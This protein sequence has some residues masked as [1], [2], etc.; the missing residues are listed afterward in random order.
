MYLV[1]NG[2]DKFAY[3]LFID[4]LTIFHR[5]ISLSQTFKCQTV[6]QFL[7]DKRVPD[8]WYSNINA[9]SVPNYCI[10]YFTLL[11]SY[12]ANHYHLLLFGYIYMTFSIFFHLAIIIYLIKM[13][14]TSV[15]TEQVRSS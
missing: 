1:C 12:I 2:I 13:G 4:F 9:K 5:K 10:N 15:V 8:E 14:L 11:W 6:G 3:F 7:A